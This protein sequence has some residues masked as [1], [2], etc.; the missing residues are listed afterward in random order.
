MAS[1]GFARV[2]EIRV[3]RIR[4]R[5]SHHQPWRERPGIRRGLDVPEF[6]EHECA[7]IRLCRGRA[8][9]AGLCNSSLGLRGS[10]ALS[11]EEPTNNIRAVLPATRAEWRSVG[12]VRIRGIR[13][14]TVLILSRRLVASSS[15]DGRRE[16][17][18]WCSPESGVR[19][20][21]QRATAPPNP[22]HETAARA[23]RRTPPSPRRS[24]HHPRSA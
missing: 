6:F 2:R 22:P 21:Q 24:P 12:F 17:G 3:S 18:V 1:V 19:S 16:T 11:A 5:P 4:G 13:V 15:R 9:T 7:R 23:S 10:G 14:L 20:N 8:T